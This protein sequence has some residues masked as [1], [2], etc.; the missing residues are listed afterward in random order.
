MLRRLE[1]ETDDGRIGQGGSGPHY[2]TATDGT[3]GVMKSTY[4]GGQ[5]HPFLY[6]NEGLCALIA[7]RLGVPV[8]EPYVLQLSLEQA[9]SFK[10]DATDADRFIFASQRIEPVE[11]L[12]PEIAAQADPRVL[13]GIVV[14]DALVWNTDR[15]DEHVLAEASDEGWR[16]WAV[17]HG[18]TL[19]MGDTLDSLPDTDRD[20][21]P[22]AL[23]SSRLSFSDLEPW[24]AAVDEVQPEDFVDLV[25]SLPEQW[26]RDSDA[27]Q[28]LARALYC[29]T[30][31][32]EQGLRNHVPPDR[33]T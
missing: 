24:L 31:F 26:L 1:L 15:K 10:P 13:A 6:L 5:S 9:H 18:H 3:K 25:R 22:F 8:P 23:L 12:T 16:I 33:Y 32:L 14:L 7:L 30:G 19:V 11:M 28:R 29:R 20:H 4:F 27:P 17:D 21:P 2:M